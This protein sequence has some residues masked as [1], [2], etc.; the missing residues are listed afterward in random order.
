MYIFKVYRISRGQSTMYA[1]IAYIQDSRA[2]VFKGLDELRGPQR[3]SARR[4]DFHKKHYP[5]GVFGAPSECDTV[6]HH[7][8]TQCTDLKETNMKQ[9][10]MNGNP[11]KDLN[12]MRRKLH[13]MNGEM[14]YFLERFG[15][16]LA[17]DK[18]YKDLGRCNGSHLAVPRQNLSLDAG[19]CEV[20]EHAG[21]PPRPLGGNAGLYCS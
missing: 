8:T 3:G 10:V 2:S 9:A 6:S 18:G 20:H 12:E 15:D 17:K 5:I 14:D 21:H 19:I 13:A 16:K 7:L 1:F 4:A 11:T